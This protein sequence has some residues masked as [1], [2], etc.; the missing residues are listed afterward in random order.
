MANLKPIVVKTELMWDDRETINIHSK[1][2][3]INLTHLSDDAVKKLTEVGVKVRNDKHDPEQGNYIV[4]KSAKY[5]IKAELEDGTPI[6][7]AKI[8]NNSKAIAT[9]MPYTWNFSGDTGVGTGVGRIV[10]TEYTEYT[11]P[12]MANPL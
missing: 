5:P 3:Q 9:V 12:S 8:A 6:I 4:V 11:G 10:V 2:Y 7:N 1:R